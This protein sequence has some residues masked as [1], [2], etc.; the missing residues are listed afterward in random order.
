MTS[1][2]LSAVASSVARRAESV[3]FALDLRPSGL[4]WPGRAEQT[5]HVGMA[6]EPVCVGFLPI[7]APS[8]PQQPAD[9]GGEGHGTEV[10]W[11]NREE[12]WKQSWRHRLASDTEIGTT[13]LGTVCRCCGRGSWMEMSSCKTFTLGPWLTRQKEVIKT[14]DGLKHYTPSNCHKTNY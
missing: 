4:L 7:T 5:G 2:F 11:P 8:S 14:L 1:F 6:R 10:S 3:F 13:G 12:P 9:P